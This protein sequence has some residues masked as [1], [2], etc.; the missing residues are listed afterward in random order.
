MRSAYTAAGLALASAAVSL[1]WAA[2]GTALLDT[3]G[4]EIE[5]LARERSA[6]TI[7]ALC[8]VVVAKLLAA[9]L[10]LSLVQRWGER[11]SRRARTLLA[12]LGGGALALYGGVLVV[13]GALV[14]SGAIDPNGDVDEHALRWH[15]F[16]WD[17]WFVV[18]GIALLAAARVSRTAP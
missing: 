4:G 6:A 13:A 2:G 5:D 8:V 12:A 3:V 1:Y 14:L 11:F 7:A 16:V 18:W 15:V 9:A 17:L 10:A